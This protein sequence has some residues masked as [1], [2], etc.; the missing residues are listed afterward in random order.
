[1]K[2]FV[3][4]LGVLTGVAFM[5]AQTTP[6]P[7]PAPAPQSPG[8]KPTPPAP[9]TPPAKPV[10]KEEPKIPGIV[11]ARSTG[12]GNQLGLT[13]S[14][15][16]YVLK[17]YDK[18]RKAIKVDVTRATARWDS[19]QKAIPEKTVLNILDGGKALGGGKPVRPPYAFKLYLTLLKGEG[20]AEKAVE[21]YVVDVT[22]A[23]LA[24]K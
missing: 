23:A 5:M 15:G 12:N 19:K 8:T 10:E 9:A 14:G 24:T 3:A 21:T 16:T 17:F 20:E 18:K 4:L 1:M 11:I 2:K 22:D 6:A 13:I 7:T